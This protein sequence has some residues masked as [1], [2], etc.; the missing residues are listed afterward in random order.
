MSGMEESEVVLKLHRQLKEAEEER[1]KAAQ[2]GLQLLESQSELQNQL[3]ELRN[4]MTGNIENLEQEKY[5][6]QREVE[7][8]GRMLESLTS[9]CECLKQQQKSQLEKQRE[10]IE[11]S[12]ARDI[13]DLKS[14]LEKLKAE[15]DETR[16]SEKQLKHKLD[17]QNEVLANKSEELR[18]MS[19]RVHETMSSEMLS[20][21]I[22]KMELET[23]K[24]QLQEE[25]N[26]LQYQQQ[27]LELANDNLRRQV[28]R[29]QEEREEREKEAVSFFNALEKA[30]E[31]IQELQIQL[32]QTLQQAQDPK[33]KGNSLF[34]EVE[35]RRAEM[36]RQL[37][38]VKVQHQSLQKQYA[39]CRQQLQRMKM[40]VAALLQ[41][42]G[43]QTDPGQ[44]E[45]LQSMLAQ[46][47]SEI[48]TLIVKLR[49]LEK[50]EMNRESE[51]S[52]GKSSATNFEDGTYYKDLLE[53]KLE[54]SK[55][56]IDKVNDELSLQRMKALSES[57]RVLEMERKLFSNERQLK[58]CQSEN[59][60]LHVKLDEMKMKYE[61]DEMRK[62]CPKR[63]R[64]KLPVDLD[65]NHTEAL[66]SS[67]PAND[68]AVVLSS[69]EKGIN[70]CKATPGENLTALR[71]L[72]I[73]STLAE[74][75]PV[76]SKRVLTDEHATKENKRVRIE[77]EPTD[78]RA[79]NEENRGDMSIIPSPRLCSSEPKLIL[80]QEEEE[81]NEVIKQ[82]KSRHRS[83]PVMRVSS[84]PTSETQCAQQ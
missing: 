78:V 46:K 25:K 33:S 59:I 51:P 37:I 19:D 9:E 50:N 57:Q 16:L 24:A 21:Q 17:Y 36:E 6:L 42:K 30:R 26:E 72:T 56:E 63:R 11:R 39:F 54:N 70:L 49:H 62:N 77:E 45:R 12:H 81:E 74:T 73:V 48:E 68:T 44:L 60:K 35:D 79:L 52:Q 53:M 41:L 32:E 3:E 55:K 80:K 66:S 76:I 13:N 5:S 23:A 10:Q 2:Y 71:E 34:A 22:E 83:Y 47:N 1:M 4:E 38:S 84:K 8:K 20:L 15:L 27:Q 65:C 69:S 64:E 18:I 58:M 31:N 82:E 29:L 67:T 43:S 75:S 7:L 28:E 14:K 40:Q 61:P